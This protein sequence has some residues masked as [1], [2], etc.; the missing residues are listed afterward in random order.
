MPKS[1]PSS[2][3]KIGA[4]QSIQHPLAESFAELEAAWLMVE[5]AADLHDEGKPCGI[6][7]NAAKYLSAE[8]SFKACERAILTH[9]GMGYAQEYD[10]ERLMREVWINRLAPI[11]QQ[12]VLNYIA[13]RALKLPRSY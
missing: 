7:A 10:V 4:H 1:G 6:E 8:A 5:K 3:K 11:S 13:E 9:G 2:A 12:M